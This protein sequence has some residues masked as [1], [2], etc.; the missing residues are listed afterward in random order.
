MAHIYKNSFFHNTDLVKVSSIIGT[1]I[2]ELK[3]NIMNLSLCIKDRSNRE[4]FRMPI[5][6]SFS[7]RGFG[8]IVTGTISSGL[9]EKNNE[10]CLLPQN[11]NAKIKE[12]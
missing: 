4:I 9:K 6:R 3:N 11:L 12:S 7:I 10:V 8:T 1:G 2:E 5:D